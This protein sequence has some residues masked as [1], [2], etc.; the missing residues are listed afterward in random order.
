MILWLV[1]A[2]DATGN[3]TSI[4]NPNKTLLRLAPGGDDVQLDLA[5]LSLSRVSADGDRLDVPVETDVLGGIPLDIPAGTYTSL[6]IELDGPLTVEGSV[7]LTLDVVDVEVSVTRQGWTLDEPHVFEL[8]MPGWLDDVEAGRR[9]VVGEALHDTLVDR[10][11][12]G[13]SLLPDT[14]GDGVPER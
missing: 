9:V 4:G 11:R 13:A 14:D 12:E 6:A 2:C 7:D 3:G 5:E 10:I 8:A 1:V